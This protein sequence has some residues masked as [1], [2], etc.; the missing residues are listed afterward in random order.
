LRCY[1]DDNLTTM[2]VV[3]ACVT[4]LP[5]PERAGRRSVR[6]I[7]MAGAWRWQYM[8]QDGSEPPA[9]APEPGTFP[10]Q[11]EAETFIGETWRELLTAGVDQVSLFEADR[12]VYGPMSLHPP[13]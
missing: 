2:P 4:S 12:K 13:G 3:A 1:G 10:S 7:T 5:A 6:L 8:A 9:S 11:A